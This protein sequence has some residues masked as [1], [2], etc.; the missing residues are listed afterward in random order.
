[1]FTLDELKETRLEKLSFAGVAGLEGGFGEDMR[2]NGDALPDPGGV[3]L[4]A[5]KAE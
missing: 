1:M 2:G 5:L 4:R 3:G